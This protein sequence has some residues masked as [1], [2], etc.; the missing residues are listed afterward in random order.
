[1]R[2]NREFGWEEVGPSQE[3]ERFTFSDEAVRH[4]VD[5]N[6]RFK[7]LQAEHPV[8]QRFLEHDSEKDQVLDEIYKSL[9][10]EVIYFSSQSGL[11]ISFDWMGWEEANYW[12][13]SERS[14]KGESV[15]MET[16]MDVE[17]ARKLITAVVRSEYFGYYTPTGFLKNGNFLF[18]FD[19]LT[20]MIARG[21][22]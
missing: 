9:A 10:S 18:I 8:V 2:V 5:I 4:M 6:E 1:M 11:M 16:V 13:F 20:G 12:L 3:G 22:R 21:E 14:N 17:T 15:N 7:A 19:R